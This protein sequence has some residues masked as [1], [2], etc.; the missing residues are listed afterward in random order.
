MQIYT[1]W[2]T[3]VQDPDEPELVTAWDEYSVDNNP[4]GF[5]K[6]VEES[7]ASWGDD[8]DQHRR[9][10]ITVPDKPI[11]DAFRSVMVEGTVE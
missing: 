7:L 1:V 3:R 4:E 11:L 2:A 10:V 6:D 8:L 9:I 5:D